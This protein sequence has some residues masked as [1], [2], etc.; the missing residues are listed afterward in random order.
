MEPSSNEVDD[1]HDRDPSASGRPRQ[2]V[3]R[4]VG[5]MLVTQVTTWCI[6]LV[7]VIALP[8]YLGSETIGQFRLVTSVWMIG[9]T[10]IGLGVH[11]VITLE[12][13]RRQEAGAATIA[14]AILLRCLTFVVVSGAVA[15][16][17]ALAG[18]GSTVVTLLVIM[19]ASTLIR[20]I[21]DVA[22]SA[23]HG[24][25]NFSL[26][27]MAVIIERFIS[28]VLILTALF[29]GAGVEVIAATGL[30]TATIHAIVIYRFLR[31]YVPLGFKASV[32]DA[33]SIGRRGLPFLFGGFAMVAYHEMDTVIISL[34]VDDEQIGWYAA[35]D[36]L[37]AT[38]LF[39]PTIVMSVLFPTFARMHQES[40]EVVRDLV[41]RGFRSLILF[42]IPI[43]FGL[44]AISTPLV[45]LLFGEEFRGSGPVLAALSI[46]LMLMFQ[47]ILIGNYAVATGHERFYYGLIFGGVLLTIPL[48]I[49]FVTWT[50]SAFEN[51]AIGGALSYIVTESLILLVAMVRFV[52]HVADRHTLIRLLKCGAAG[53]LMLL[54]VWPLR[55]RVIVLPIA[56]GAIVYLGVVFAL[57]TLTEEER[58]GISAAIGQVKDRLRPAGGA[59]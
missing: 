56:A 48:D 28:M 46:V 44:A 37:T 29:V 23:L 1:T 18:Y 5:V 21:G 15:V 35:A 41:A 52:P 22:V 20:S 31:R 55:E 6:S 50:N 43:G 4:N 53:A 49:A 51:G 16:F 36:R 19:G 8:R 13:A 42:S 26:P 38:S 59:E 33:V 39:I 17:V 54:A 25:E 40:P 27:A 9:A 7:L 45:L 34:L 12:I 14:P 32:G 58:S 30:V 47:T 11:M 10:F 3:R 24:F 57:S 2:S